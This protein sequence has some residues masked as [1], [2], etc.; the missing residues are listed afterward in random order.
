MRLAQEQTDLPIYKDN[1]VVGNGRQQQFRQFQPRNLNNTRSLSSDN[2]MTY[3]HHIQYPQDS[4][5]RYHQQHVID[6]IPTAHH[7]PENDQLQRQY[8]S[9]QER[10]QF[11]NLQPSGY[12]GSTSYNHANYMTSQDQNMIPSAGMPDSHLIVSFL[13]NPSDDYASLS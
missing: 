4:I 13:F 8:I 9:S 10:H 5:N 12:L 6:R 1:Y 7:N 2:S 3:S 11:N